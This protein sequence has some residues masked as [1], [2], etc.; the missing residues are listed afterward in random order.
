M[1]C[2]I[3]ES[4]PLIAPSSLQAAG[5]NGIIRQG[6]FHPWGGNRWILLIRHASIKLLWF[7]E[8][9][10]CMWQLRGWHKKPLG[11]PLG[12]LHL[13]VTYEPQT[14]C[15]QTWTCHFFTLK[16]VCPLFRQISPPSCLS[17]TLGVAFNTSLPWS[18]NPIFP[19]ICPFYFLGIYLVVAPVPGPQCS[20]S[21]HCP[22]WSPCLQVCSH[23]PIL[24]HC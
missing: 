16:N 11:A 19:K 5:S 23:D 9:A 13:A 14:Q 4:S 21:N 7:A 18:P 24:H 22:I 17:Q 6:A 10:M 1:Q 12:C 15:V 20:A 2:P 8:S 3:L